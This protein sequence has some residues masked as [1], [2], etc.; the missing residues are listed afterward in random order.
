VKKKFRVLALSALFLAAAPTFATTL[1]L[2]ALFSSLFFGDPSVSRHEL[3]NF[4]YDSSANRI[5]HRGSQPA[6]MDFARNE[7]IIG[8]EVD[9]VRE[10]IN[11]QEVDLVAGLGA[12]AL[13]THAVRGN[14]KQMVFIDR[15]EGP[16]IVNEYFWK[17]LAAISSSPS[18]LVTH[19]F[20]LSLPARLKNAS[21]REAWEYA[22]AA[23]AQRK[24]SNVSQAEIDSMNDEFN[25]KLHNYVK[26]LSPAEAEGV[27]RVLVPIMESAL[28]GSYNANGVFIGRVASG[29]E[30]YQ[31]FMN[32]Y[33]SPA[34]DAEKGEDN[35]N[36]GHPF[37]HPF[38]SQEAFDR[39]K[40]LMPESLY[41]IGDMRSAAVTNAL[42]NLVQASSHK[43]VVINHSNFL[44]ANQS[45]KAA[46]GDIVELNNGYVAWTKKLGLT[47]LRSLYTRGVGTLHAFQEHQITPETPVARRSLFDLIPA[48]LRE[49]PL[50]NGSYSLA[51]LAPRQAATVEKEIIA[52]TR[53]LYDE[54]LREKGRHTL[55]PID[56]DYYAGVNRA[57]SSTQFSQVSLDERGT[58]KGFVIAYYSDQTRTLHLDKIGVLPQHRKQGIMKNL[59]HRSVQN[60]KKF[61]I[62]E[63]DLYVHKENIEAQ[64]A[65]AKL[66][67]KNV[68][69]PEY[70]A[71]PAYNAY[72]FAVPLDVLL[73]NTQ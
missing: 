3:V 31:G 13:W 34:L 55:F 66:G 17:P 73:Q 10:P 4:F 9:Y 40:K 65:Y 50:L 64:E 20:G 19:M 1:C 24:K 57:D 14:A 68:T 7:F 54:G 67:F 56:S 5:L 72:R 28:F 47:S 25:K 41:V 29:T 38:A 69:P 39:W 60:A 48:S 59:I 58:V 63:V 35:P 26:T 32:A 53:N 2:D 52:A 27:R 70:S 51:S 33:V 21:L 18:E 71:D 46:D 45:A 42:G 23:K 11:T 16:A 36:L 43:S 44:E 12:N 49:V 15:A 6:A 22:V 30:L 8:N 37:L 62:R 61:N